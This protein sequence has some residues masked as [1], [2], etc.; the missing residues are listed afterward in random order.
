[1]GTLVLTDRIISAPSKGHKENRIP[2]I[3]TR[4]QLR[5]LTTRRIRQ[6][7]MIV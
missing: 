7:D 1:M 4:T 5:R 2:S 6:N 3:F